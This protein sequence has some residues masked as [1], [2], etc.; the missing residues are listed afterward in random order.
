MKSLSLNITRYQPGSH[1]PAH[2]HDA[3]HLS[4]V[5]HG[6]L[7]ESIGGH[8]EPMGPMS[9]V[10]KDPGV[11]HANRWGEQGALI[12]RL[13]IA[14]H[15][16]G[17]VA[18]RTIHHAWSWQRDVAVA[19]P[20]LRIVSRA[21]TT[22]SMVSPDDADLPDLIAALTARRGGELRSDPPAWLREVVALMR[23][24][25][26]PGLSVGDVARQAGVHPVYLA[27]CMKRWY[28]TSVGDELRRIRLRHAARGLANLAVSVAQIAHEN[29]FADES[30]L[31]RSLSDA[32]SFTPLRL[33]KVV[34][35][36]A[37]LARP[38]G[39]LGPVGR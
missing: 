14:G 13:S 27:R 33:R 17:D 19:A 34:S 4:L 22:D 9:V 18:D 15:G 12:A 25:W 30:H 21:R 39:G 1:Q 3:L 7:A 5:L 20:F 36:A 6:G 2:A 8:T 11:T 38:A 31:C 26:H 32:T 16:L 24:G 28:R 23:D 37:A 35:H 29:G 10:S